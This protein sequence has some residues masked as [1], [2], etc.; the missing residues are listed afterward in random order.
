M[1]RCESKMREILEREMRDREEEKERAIAEKL[2]VNWGEVV[3]E[4]QKREGM[5]LMERG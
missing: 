5:K 4:R 3:R 2:R 1:R